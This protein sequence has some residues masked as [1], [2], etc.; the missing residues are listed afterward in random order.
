MVVSLPRP[1][2][3]DL[4]ETPCAGRRAGA[5][6]RRNDGLGFRL[7]GANIDAAVFGEGRRIALAEKLRAE[8]SGLLLTCDK[9]LWCDVTVGSFRLGSRRVRS[10]KCACEALAS[11]TGAPAAASNRGEKYVS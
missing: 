8:R 7:G 3:K 9:P 1:E 10:V 2:R 11:K 5:E 4:A 6:S